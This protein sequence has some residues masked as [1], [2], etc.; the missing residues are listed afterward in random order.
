MKESLELL[1]S[2]RQHKLTAE[3]SGQYS[4]SAANFDKEKVPVKKKEGRK[5]QKF[6]SSKKWEKL[7]KIC[8]TETV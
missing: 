6:V 7:E 8:E 1:L 5:H 4:S 3:P 2:V